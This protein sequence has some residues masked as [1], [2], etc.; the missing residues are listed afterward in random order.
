ML[1]T[2]VTFSEL[3]IL[4]EVQSRSKIDEA[5]CEAQNNLDDLD[6]DSF[7]FTLPNR[8]RKFAVERIHNLGYQDLKTEELENEETRFKVYF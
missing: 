8:L 3:S 2:P 5:I 1:Y 7:E 6:V 4:K